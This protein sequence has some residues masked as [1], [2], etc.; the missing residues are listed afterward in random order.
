MRCTC[1]TDRLWIIIIEITF[2]FRAREKGRSPHE[3]KICIFKC[4]INIWA[5]MSFRAHSGVPCSGGKYS[6]YYNFGADHSWLMAATVTPFTFQNSLILMPSVVRYRTFAM[7]RL[8][9]SIH[10]HCSNGFTV[11]PM[12]PVLGAHTHTHKRAIC[13]F[14]GHRRSV[15]FHSVIFFT[16]TSNCRGSGRRTEKPTNRTQCTNIPLAEQTVLDFSQTWHALRVSSSQSIQT[17]FYQST[18]RCCL[19]AC[20]CAR[21]IAHTPNIIAQRH[22]TVA[23]HP[24]KRWTKRTST[25]QR[26]GQT[27]FARIN[28]HRVRAE[29]VEH[30][31]HTRSTEPTECEAHGKTSHESHADFPVFPSARSHCVR[32]RRHSETKHILRSP[33]KLVGARSVGAFSRLATVMWFECVCECSRF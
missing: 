11:F 16:R 12:Y 4:L 19:F 20:V 5:F 15:S 18:H 9:T 17:Y 27:R 28:K 13:R 32:A 1:I 33:I 10:Q 23:S 30:T 21:F 29:C 2:Y 14:Y 31:V 24:Q 6:A 7:V 22:K 8:R 3:W 26:H 25:P